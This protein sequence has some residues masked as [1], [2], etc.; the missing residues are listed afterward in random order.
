MNKYACRI[1]IADFEDLCSRKK[2]SERSMVL[3]SAEQRDEIA[4]FFRSKNVLALL[5]LF[6]LNGIRKIVV[7]QLSFGLCVE[8]HNLGYN[9]L[10]EFVISFYSPRKPCN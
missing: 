10:R 1:K 4:I 8:L 2:F 6:W 7:F 3:T 5:F 9:E